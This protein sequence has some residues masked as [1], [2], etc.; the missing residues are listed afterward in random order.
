MPGRQ[1]P[2]DLLGLEPG[3]DVVVLAVQERDGRADSREVRARVEERE[4]IARGLEPGLEPLPRAGAEA[5][6]DEEELAQPDGQAGRD[7]G[8]EGIARARRLQLH[9]PPR[10][11]DHGVPGGLEE[12]AVAV[13]VEVLEQV[14]EHRRAVER[15][16]G[17]LDAAALVLGDAR[18]REAHRRVEIGEAAEDDERAHP[19][20]VRGTGAELDRRH[21]S[22]RDREERRR[23]QPV[24][25][26][27]GLEQIERGG[28]VIGRLRLEPEA[29]VR[30]EEGREDDEPRRGEDAA[31]AV[32]PGIVRPEVM[33][34]RRDEVG[35]RR[36]PAPRRVE[37]GL[38]EPRRRSRLAIDRR[39]DA[40]LGPRPEPAQERDEIDRVAGDRHRRGRSRYSCV[41][42][43]EVCRF[44]RKLSS[45]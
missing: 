6:A 31:E 25:R 41:P 12:A 7:L 44:Q 40:V 39:R 3:D 16:A 36:R 23:R 13:D 15:I 9:P 18:D 42:T 37:V 17:E 22:E 1:G 38:A 20:A 2:P 21:R 4:A 8:G 11:L 45:S 29:Q 35:T 10:P 32:E 33:Q 14:Q 30:R 43:D 34:P 26:R 24:L 28:E 27:D 19:I 5:A